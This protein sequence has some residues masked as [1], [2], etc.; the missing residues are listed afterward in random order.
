[1]LDSSKREVWF[2]DIF[3]DQNTYS[4]EI[5]LNMNF[6]NPVSNFFDSLSD[7]DKAFHFSTYD[8]DLN[9]FTGLE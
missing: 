2:F 1:M 7:S 5:T 4:S 3:R 8:F 6:T 9:D